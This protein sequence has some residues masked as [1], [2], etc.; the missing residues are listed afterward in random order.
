MFVGPGV[1]VAIIVT[2]PTGTVASDGANPT[3]SARHKTGPIPEKESVF[4]MPFFIVKNAAVHLKNDAL[5]FGGGRATIRK[6]PW[7]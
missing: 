3:L 5:C 2:V 6:L 1:I 7:L 4:F